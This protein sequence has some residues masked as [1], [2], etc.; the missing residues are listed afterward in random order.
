[1]VEEKQRG[2]SERDEA[3]KAEIMD[4]AA[5]CFMERGFE[6]T[7]IDKIADSYG[8]TKGLI[9]YH[10]RSKADLFF[11]VYRRAISR[12]IARAEPIALGAGRAAERLRAMSRGHLLGV[13]Q[14]LAYHHVSKQGVEMHLASALTPEQ[15]EIL[16]DLIKLRDV[17]EALYVKV[18][19][20][21]VKDGTIRCSDAA[22]TARTILGGLNGYSV[23]YRFRA[24]QSR[25]SREALAEQVVD[26]VLGGVST[27]HCEDTP[28][29]G[30][31]GRRRLLGGGRAGLM[32]REAS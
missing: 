24:G 23:W 13:M 28:T 4:A 18:L 16:R 31:P 14:N 17:Y 21:G 8:S 6:A 32:R 7:T 29:S 10:F 15:N 2:R 11:E 12:T 9:Y 27:G 1:M 26:V 22:L 3:K 30:Q 19:S 25:K 5:Q 20:D